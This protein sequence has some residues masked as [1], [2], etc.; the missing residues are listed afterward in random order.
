MIQNN[1]KDNSDSFG[2][3]SIYE[4]SHILDCSHVFIHRSVIKGIVAMVSIMCKIPIIST[5]NKSMNLFIWCTNPNGINTEICKIAIIELLSKPFQ[6]AAMER[7]D[8]FTSGINGW[9]TV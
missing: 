2:M 9:S 7:S 3:C 1:V 8:I 4:S 5:T 6:I